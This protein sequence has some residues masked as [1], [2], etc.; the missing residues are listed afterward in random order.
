MQVKLVTG[1]SQ[2][3]WVDVP[4]PTPTPG[5]AVVD[6]AYCGICG[7]DLHAYQSGEPYNPAICGHEWVGHVAGVGAAVGHVREGDRVAIGVGAACGQCAPCRRGQTS[8]CDTVFASATGND[9]KAASH[10]GFAPAINFDA[11]RLY[12]VPQSLTDIEA[13]ILEPAA[14]AVHA[15][16]R[17]PMQFGDRVVVIGG[18][19]IGLLVLQAARLHGASQVL[20]VEPQAV[21][22]E[23]ALTLGADQ[24]LTPDEH[25]AEAIN[26]HCHGA[27]D[28]V[29]ECAGVAST[30]Q[31]AVNLVRRGGV[32]ALVGVANTPAE[33]IPALW[34][35]KEVNVVASIAYLHEDFDLTKNFVADGLIKTAPLHTS[36]VSLAGLGSAFERLASN[37]SE[38]KILVDPRL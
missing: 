28:V 29:F 18:G 21:R 14:V 23:M 8:H 15:A 20:L 25:L 36:T 31:L 35:A 19:P 3:E 13:G 12:H 32:V 7:T 17:T 4:E 37:P 16:R 11:N 34:L 22:A 5:C 24:V 33:I 27:P 6:I 10:G 30:I 1:K 2:I 26:T 9:A 38:V